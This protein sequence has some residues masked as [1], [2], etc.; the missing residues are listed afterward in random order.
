MSSP[1]ETKRFY[2]THAKQYKTIAI[3]GLFWAVTFLYGIMLRNRTLGVTFMFMSLI[4]P[5]VILM[6]YLQDLKSLNYADVTEEGILT[7]NLG[8]FHKMTRWAEI[9]SMAVVIING[10]ETIGVNFLPEYKRHGVAAS[11]SMRI[12]GYQGLLRQGVATD[13][14]TFT[15]WANEHFIRSSSKGS[16]RTK[17]ERQAVKAE[18]V[19]IK[20]SFKISDLWSKPYAT[21][22][23]GALLV[24]DILAGML[25][26]DY[27]VLSSIFSVAGIIST[28]MAGASLIRFR[29]VSD[30]AHERQKAKKPNDW[31]NLT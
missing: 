17:A 29:R 20:Q 19:Q 25:R 31:S 23:V 16:K 4:Y 2:Y 15:D 21:A 28:G 7:T 12:S 11:T 30:E 26:H 27:H 10:A 5:L 9:E 6:S 22:W 3:L 1:T 18:P 24:C 14:Q 8:L 13:G